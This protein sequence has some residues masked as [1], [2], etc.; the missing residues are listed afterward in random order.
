MFK[1]INIDNNI[2]QKALQEL[3]SKKYFSFFDNNTKV[4]T[5]F[6]LEKNKMDTVYWQCTVN[7][8][9]ILKF[10]DFHLGDGYSGMKISLIKLASRYTISIKDYTDNLNSVNSKYEIIHQKIILDK[11]NYKKGDSIFGR[12]DLKILEKQNKEKFIHNAGGYFKG[13]I[14]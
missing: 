7:E 8:A 4:T 12:V 13:K 11:E 6:S 5:D 14:N 10:I 9:N 2:K 3:N 1:H